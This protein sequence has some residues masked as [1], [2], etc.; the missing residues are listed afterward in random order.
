M[1]GPNS[2]A[3]HGDDISV[4]HHRSWPYALL[5]KNLEETFKEKFNLPP[6]ATVLFLTGSGTLANEAVAASLLRPLSVRYQGEEF[7]QRLVKLL[8]TWRK[9][10]PS[11]YEHAMVYYE[12]ARALRQPITGAPVWVDAV[13]AFPYYQIPKAVPMFTT[14]SG[15]GLGGLPGLGIVVVQSHGWCLLEDDKKYSYLNLERYH[16]YQKLGQPPHTPAISLMVDLLERLRRFSVPLHREGIDRRREQIM[17]AYP[18]ASGE[19][20]VLNL[21]VPGE[22]A[23]RFDLYRSNH[24]HQ[25]FLWSGSDHDYDVFCK[26]LKEIKIE[27]LV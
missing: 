22:F 26:A 16:H 11:M 10:H 8:T 15:K 19:G 6:D 7:A 1:F 14:V 17:A 23:Q 9:Y 18:L 21:Q 5:L 2:R 13:S 25:V 27:N 20:P 24:G 12:T 4:F 3:V